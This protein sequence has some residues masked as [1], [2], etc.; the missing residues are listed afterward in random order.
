M[1]TTAYLERLGLDADLPATHAS[2]RAVHRAH[3]QQVPYDN[4]DIMLGRPTSTVPADSVARVATTGRAGYC[5]HQNGALGSVLADLGFAV[6]SRH[7][8]VWTLPEQRDRPELNHLALVV[9]GLP[10]PA[11]PGGRWWCDVGL[12]AGGFLDPAPLVEGDILDGPFRFEVRAVRDG[13][14][15]YRNDPRGTFAGL[16]V[17]HRP[18]GQAAVDAAH[19]ALSTPPD[20]RFTRVLV[21][22]RRDPLGADTVRGCTATRTD[23]AGVSRRDLT[24]YDEWRGALDAIGLVVDDVTEDDL[25]ALFD[26]SLESHRTWDAAGRP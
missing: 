20:G 17:R 23:T 6:E 8:H 11:N 26:R 7:G 5:F 15:S 10:T 22:E 4:L 13:G 9:A 24:S 12:G 18:V 21:V 19:A 25:R 16:E 2:L 3:A 14:W 1:S